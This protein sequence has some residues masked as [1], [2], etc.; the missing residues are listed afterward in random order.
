MEHKK[1]TNF[2][3]S[4]GFVLAAAG[5]A[6][7]V[8]TIWRFP[9]LAARDGGGIF[10]L[11]YLVL[12]LTFGFTLLT[13]DITIGRRTGKN[14]WQAFGSICPKWGFLGKLTFLVPAMIM[15]YYS[16]IGGW[17]LKYATRYLTGG[18]RAAAEDGF[19][20]SF[21]TSDVAPIVFMLV[22]L[23]FTALIV[24]SGVEKGIERFAKVIMPG[25][26]LMVIGIAIYS[27]TLKSTG[28][29]GVVRTGLQGFLFYI[30]PRCAGNSLHRRVSGG[31]WQRR[32]PA[33]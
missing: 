12:V 9:Y 11:V 14:A 25:L 30:K 29:D 21:I 1:T 31:K 2:T 6:V 5:S 20:V 8:G 17:I 10:L 22:F 18:H 24:Y 13:T 3:S 27:L 32:F 15:T 26:L 23:A 7:G 4:L 16:V 28:A 19:F 33:F